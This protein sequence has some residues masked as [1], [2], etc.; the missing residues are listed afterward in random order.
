MGDAVDLHKHFIEV[1]LVAGAGAP[2]AQLVGVDLPELRT[3]AP[4]RFIT[5]HNTTR[6]HQL[7]DLPKAQREPKVQPHTMVDD[8]DRVA[9]ALVRRR[10]GAH[11]TDPSRTPTLTNV[12][13][14][15]KV[16]ERRPGVPPHAIGPGPRIQ[17]D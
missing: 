16:P 14:P 15:T 7:L 11:P 13:A 6:K 10:C 9:V 1:P 3:P 4:D 12:T 2:P 5:D 8:L 17:P